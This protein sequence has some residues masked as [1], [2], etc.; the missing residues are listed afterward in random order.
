MTVTTIN[1][2]QGEKVMIVKVDKVVVEAVVV[3]VVVEDSMEVTKVEVVVVVVVEVVAVV[4]VIT[5]NLEAMMVKQN[6]IH[7]KVIHGVMS[8]KN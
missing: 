4:A 2:G 7:F 8:N 3:V 6:K 5:I 1:Q